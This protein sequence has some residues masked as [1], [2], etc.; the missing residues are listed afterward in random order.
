[1]LPHVTTVVVSF[2]AATATA[3]SFKFEWD[4]TKSL[5]T[6]NNACFAIYTKKYKDTL[7]YDSDVKIRDQRR[8]QSG[9]SRNPCNDAKLSYGKF[10]KSCD[11]FPFASTKEGGTGAF[12]RC[13][14]GAENSSEGGQ[15]GNF[16]KKMK[17]GDTFKLFIRNYKG[18]R[19]C[20]SPGAV[21]DG[22]Q[23]TLKNSQF[24]NSKLRMAKR[25]MTPFETVADDLET[26]AF[27]GEALREYEDSEGNRVLALSLGEE[28]M[29]G[30]LISDGN[31]TLTIVKEV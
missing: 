30:Q 27:A 11:E 15:L 23:F 18:A 19:F 12:L 3:A 31:R 8:I 28:I 2:L 4:C 24:V 21:N 10:G 22:G 5:G 17:T 9:C 6:C 16:Y 25:G 7:T 13:V 26:P 29:V 1:M 20:D 14:D